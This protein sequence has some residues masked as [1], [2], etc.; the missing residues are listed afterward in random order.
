MAASWKEETQFPPA[1][2]RPKREREREAAVSLQPRAEAPWPV[3]NSL[4]V[5]NRQQEHHAATHGRAQRIHHAG[6]S[7]VASAVSTR[8][9]GAGGEAPRLGRRNRGQTVTDSLPVPLVFP[10]K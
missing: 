9:A 5:S 2:S 3:T 1:L 10:G 6:D 8:G 7:A 4:C